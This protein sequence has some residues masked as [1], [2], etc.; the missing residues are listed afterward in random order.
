MN[1]VAP[2][3]VSYCT[4]L[5]FSFSNT[6]RGEIINL[7][8]YSSFTF[9]IDVD[10]IIYQGASANEKSAT[11]CIIGG[12]NKFV[13]SK[14]NVPHSTY[15]ITE[16]QKLTLYKIMKDLSKFTD[17]AKIT[18]NHDKLEQSLNALYFNYC[19]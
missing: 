16:Q 15:Y 10:G 12:L 13:N 4:G 18:A 9:I 17:S 19:G 11:V 7:N 5:D 6:T 8:D 14:L 2:S 3:A 1:K